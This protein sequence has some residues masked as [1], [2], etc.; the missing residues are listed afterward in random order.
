VKLLTI[1][2][3]MTQQFSLHHLLGSK[4]SYGAFK[5][6]DIQVTKSKLVI[7]F[8]ECKFIDEKNY[9]LIIKLMEMDLAVNVKSQRESIAE[10]M[11]ERE[12]GWIISQ[13]QSR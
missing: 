5:N 10:K 4:D 9:K 8:P 1:K 11:I 12:P 3:L 6:I 7:A 2:D 13:R